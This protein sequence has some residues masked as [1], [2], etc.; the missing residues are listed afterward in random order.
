MAE[1]PALYSQRPIVNRHAK[2]AMYHP[3]V[4]SI[5]LTVVDVP[6][7]ILTLV[8]FSIIL[9]FLTG[10][11]RSAGQFLYVRKYFIVFS[12]LTQWSFSTF[13]LLVI[14]V[15]LT[16]KAFFRSLAAFF[17][18][19]ANAQSMAGIFTLVLVLYTGFN[20]PKPTMIGALRWITYVRI[21]M[22]CQVDS[23]TDS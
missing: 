7:T 22:I 23:Y 1:I 9:Y 20:I 19:E 5:A 3:F 18:S 15:S 16:M 6:I 11:Q 12:L 21:L 4:E 10:L 17:N 14:V 2:S 8:F 13:L